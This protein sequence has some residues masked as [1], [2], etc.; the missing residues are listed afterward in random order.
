MLSKSQWKEF[1]DAGETPDIDLTDATVSQLFGALE[2]TSLALQAA[3]CGKPVRNADEIISA[4][5]K[6][7]N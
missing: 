5:Q 3:I 6:I 2:E 4:N 1:Q 7:L